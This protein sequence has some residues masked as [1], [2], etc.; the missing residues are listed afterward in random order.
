MDLK[1]RSFILFFVNF[2]DPKFKLVTRL[3]GLHFFYYFVIKSKQVKY[4]F[5]VLFNNLLTILC[6]LILLRSNGLI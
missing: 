6:T 3:D 4:K 1:I 5:K 2:V